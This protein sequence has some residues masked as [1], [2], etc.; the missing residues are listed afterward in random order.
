MLLINLT[1]ISPQGFA[2]Q[3]LQAFVFGQSLQRL[4]F[5]EVSVLSSL[6]LICM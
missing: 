6:S 1:R 3:N 4:T 2:L 5:A